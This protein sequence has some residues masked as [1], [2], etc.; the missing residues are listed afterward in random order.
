M[1]LRDK[2]TDDRVHVRLI[3]GVT[4]TPLV[5]PRLSSTVPSDAV[6]RP[7]PGAS[8]GPLR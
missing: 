5:L 2:T 8:E 1:T 7:R 6:R 3:Q 4:G